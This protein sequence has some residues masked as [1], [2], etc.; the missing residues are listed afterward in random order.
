[1]VEIE[2]EKLNK[3]F[4]KRKVLKDVSFQVSKGGFLSVF[5]PNGAGKTTL[6]KILSTLVAPSSGKV[7][8]AGTSLEEDS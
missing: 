3:S 6:L 2:V 5:G 8:V 7:I 1:M 4:G